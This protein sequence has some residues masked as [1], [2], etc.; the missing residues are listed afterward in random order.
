MSEQSSADLSAYSG[1]VNAVAARIRGLWLSYIAL[2]TYLGIT[3]STVTHRDLFLNNPITLPVLNVELPLIG[4]FLVAP[5]L[6]LINHFYLLLQLE[7]L[8]IRV[9]E[10]NA[11]VI[12]AYDNG[13][14]SDKAEWKE[15]RALDSFVVVQL[16][17]GIQHERT[18]RIGLCFR[19]IAWITLVLAPVV[20]LLQIQLE[21]LPYHLEWMTW[22]HRA[23]LIFDLALLGVFWRHILRRGE[24]EESWFCPNR[25]LVIVAVPVIFFSCFVATF[26]GEQI[27]KTEIGGNILQLSSW[28]TPKGLIVWPLKRRLS[29]NLD[30][31]GEILI[32]TSKLAQIQMRK[33][34]SQ[35][36]WEGE[37]TLYVSRPYAARNLIGANLHDVDL[38]Y[39][40]LSSARLE[41]ASLRF[42]RLHGASLMRARLLGANLI[43]VQL[44]G[45]SLERTELHGAW[46]DGAQLQGAMLRRAQIQGASFDGAQLQAVTLDYAEL[47]GASFVGAELQGASLAGAQ[48]Q[49]ALFR[50]AQ[51]QG[52]SLAGANF[53]SASLA[54]TF[55]W[56]AYGNPHVKNS[57]I[58]GTVAKRRWLAFTGQIVEFTMDAYLD[59]KARVVQ[60]V[61]DEA[62]RK[63]ILERLQVLDPTESDP[64][65]TLELFARDPR[66]DNS[67]YFSHFRHLKDILEQLACDIE[68]APYVAEGLSLH[69][70]IVQTGPHAG[71]LAQT[72]LDASGSS[73][74]AAEKCPG[75]RGISDEA[76]ARLRRIVRE[77]R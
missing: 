27:D 32:D 19:L 46:L 63:H 21:F 64:D 60:G 73:R 43:G 69:G 72:L 13:G 62:T 55:L 67:M 58:S 76:K 22:L 2:L 51:L 30:L 10:F 53:E 7:G 31:T 41:G 17:G 8:A 26:P 75:A 56:R 59:L 74:T 48:L 3:V 40:D 77:G 12:E 65:E 68:A 50:G 52:A 29:R 49:G 34:S 71:A 1:P 70:Q 38:R 42:A 20:V 36:P 66:F 57:L 61:V 44:Q 47:Q 39:V 23:S 5:L 54:E 18:G 37:R 11:A 9:H 45:A 14:L 28:E 6:L 35:E 16:L 25:L 4:F 33:P 15:R 24:R